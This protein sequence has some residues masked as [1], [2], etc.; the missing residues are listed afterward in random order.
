VKLRRLIAD[1]AAAWFVVCRAYAYSA[2]V[3]PGT[4]QRWLKQGSIDN[5]DGQL[6]TWRRD[7]RRTMI[8]RKR[9][10]RGMSNNQQN[11]FK[12]QGLRGAGAGPA[13]D[14]AM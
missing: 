13:S 5:D 10:T 12:L 2:F 4:K 11:D 6:R 14:S 7:W 8:K 3:T 1:A 9:T